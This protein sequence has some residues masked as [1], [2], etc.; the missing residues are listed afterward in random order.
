MQNSNICP[1]CNYKFPSGDLSS[2]PKCGVII[3]KYIKMLDEKQKEFE[4]NN[5]N[6]EYKDINPND[7]SIYNQINNKNMYCRNCGKEVHEKAI[8]CPACGVPPRLENKYCYN[9]GSRTDPNQ[10]MCVKCGFYQ[11]STSV[12]ADL[13]HKKLA[14]GL[15]GIFLGGLGIHKFYLGYNKQGIIML[16]IALIGGLFTMGVAMLVVGAVGFIE[17]I[18]YLTKSDQEF[19]QTYLTGDK[20]WF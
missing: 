15:L 10:T 5:R 18:I 17:G 7:N 19:E 8:A 6:Q 12:L 4:L 16:L 13:K 2:C 11:S 20:G 14:A 3:D 9:C 1:K